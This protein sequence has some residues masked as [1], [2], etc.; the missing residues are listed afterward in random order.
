M[1]QQYA[2]IDKITKAIPIGIARR[3][4]KI[5]IEI[6]QLVDVQFFRTQISDSKNNLSLQF[7]FSAGSDSK[8]AVLSCEVSLNSQNQVTFE[9]V[10]FGSAVPDP[11]A[12][13]I[14]LKDFRVKIVEGVKQYETK[15]DP[16]GTTIRYAS[17]KEQ[18]V[19]QSRIIVQDPN[20]I[21][22]G[23]STSFGVGCVWKYLG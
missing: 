6:L 18:R 21:Y 19:N 13:S 14:G 9:N 11:F 17:I 4:K 8:I 12:A 23:A 10:A 15:K 22:S 3:R 7:T 5:P 1:I 2:K 20:L 16:E